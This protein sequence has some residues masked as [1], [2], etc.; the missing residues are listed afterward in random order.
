MKRLN[1]GIIGQGRSGYAI[2]ANI[3]RLMPGRFNIAAVSEL[4][5]D[6]LDFAVKELKCQGYIDYKE[7][8]KRQDLDLVVNATPSHLHVPASLDVL[9]SGHNLLCEKPLARYAS[10]VDIIIKKAGETGKL[11]AIFQ[12]SRYAP[13][14]QQVKKVIDSGVLG[15]IVMVRI[16]FNGFARRWDWQTLM[17]MNGGNLLNTGPHPLDQALQL[18]GTDVMPEVF[19][20]MDRVNT[21]GDAE[22]HVK[23]ILHG[24]DRPTIDLEI[25]SCCAY[26]L[27]TY[28]IYGANGGLSGNMTH[29]DWKYFKPEEAPAQKLCRE[30]LPGRGYCGESLKWYT[31]KWDVPKSQ[32]NLFDVMGK[33]FYKNIYDA[34]TTGAPLT[35]TPLE[36]RQQIAVIEECHRQDQ[37]RR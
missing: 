31:D 17:D 21:F 5:A 15:R 11:F 14:F 2:H 3:L 32:S 19:C 10:D 25:S 18:F 8:L 6:R 30:S 4:D 12:Q 23:L 37:S 1:V 27:Y 26:P 20:L 9:D 13:Y 33:A 35:I 36:V 24:K 22:D 28:Q 7:M 34:I 29:M 16:A